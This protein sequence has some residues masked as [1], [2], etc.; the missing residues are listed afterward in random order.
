VHVQAEG[1]T[2][3]LPGPENALRALFA[4]LELEPPEEGELRLVARLDSEASVA[5]GDELTLSL[6]PGRVML[7]DGASG[8]RMGSG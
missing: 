6:D 5:A 3:G 8:E 4:E 1:K 7:F 2:G